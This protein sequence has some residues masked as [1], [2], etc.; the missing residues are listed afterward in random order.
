[1]ALKVGTAVP[2]GITITGCNILSVDKKEEEVFVESVADEGDAV[3]GKLLRNKV[4][5]TIK[6]EMTA[7]AALPSKGTGANTAASPRIRT[8]N[9]GDQNEKVS[10]FEV[11]AEYI[12]APGVDQDV[13]Y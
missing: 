2:T 1:M 6:G 8:V 10:A 11:V 4:T 7:A 3:S 5:L 13:D 12:E 9:V